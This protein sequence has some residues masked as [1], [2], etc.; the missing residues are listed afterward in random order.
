L[1]DAS[2][3]GYTGA[4]LGKEGRGSEGGREGIRMQ[5]Q[6]IL[7]FPNKNLFD[8]TELLLLLLLFASGGIYLIQTK[9]MKQI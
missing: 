4:K 6:R 9:E 3:D 1:F 8:S 2:S 5:L 7:Q